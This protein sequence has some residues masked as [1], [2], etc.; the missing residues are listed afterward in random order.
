M[1]TLFTKILKREI[2]GT[3]VYEDDQCAALL[4]ITP[5]APTHILVVPKKEISSVA[6]A[7]PEDEQLLGHLLVVAARVAR[8][9]GVAGSGYRL[10]I[11]HGADAGQ[12][13]PHIHVHL[14]GGRAL[15]WPPG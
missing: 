14:L 11:N 8:D 2:P 4:D 9:Q 5:V 12:T 1:A 10:V 3:I 15:E 13:V 6:T 7:L